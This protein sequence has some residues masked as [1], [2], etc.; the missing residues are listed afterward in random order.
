M[1]NDQKLN[2]ALLV[3]KHV[4]CTIFVWDEPEEKSLI[5]SV[6]HNCNVNTFALVFVGMI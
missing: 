6:I 5:S 4:M 3:G 2:N 1:L